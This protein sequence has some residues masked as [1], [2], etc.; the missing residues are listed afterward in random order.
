MSRFINKRTLTLILGILVVILIVLTTSYYTPAIG[1]APIE[2]PFSDMGLDLIE[3][4]PLI[5]KT[6]TLLFK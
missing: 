4:K 1:E 5:T 2:N 3:I 6:K